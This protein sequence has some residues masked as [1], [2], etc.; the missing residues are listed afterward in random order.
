MLPAVRERAQRL[1]R[2]LRDD[3]DP[4]QGRSRS[5]QPR[6]QQTSQ[7]RPRADEPRREVAEES[8]KSKVSWD[9]EEA[10][11]A[12]RAGK[13]NVRIK[14]RL[15]ESFYLFPSY[16]AYHALCPHSCLPSRNSPTR[17]NLI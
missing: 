2:F 10:E 1:L 14:A 15:L 4:E 7:P 12:R 8:W 6:A 5:E 13:F 16:N 3:G 17:P 9:E 11:D